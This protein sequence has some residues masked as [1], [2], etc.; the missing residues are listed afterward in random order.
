L[1]TGH[2]QWHN[3][4]NKKLKKHKKKEKRRIK[5]KL[6]KITNKNKKYRLI[7]EMEEFKPILLLII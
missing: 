2:N 3:K 6:S 5:I 1:K 7:L 4:R